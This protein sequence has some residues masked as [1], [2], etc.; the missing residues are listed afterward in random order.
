MDHFYKKNDAGKY[1]I[2]GQASERQDIR[3]IRDI[4]S[5]IDDD[6]QSLLDDVLEWRYYNRT[7]A[8]NYVVELHQIIDQLKLFI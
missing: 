4:S 8:S 6:L 3:C 1:F 7:T 5:E 2:N